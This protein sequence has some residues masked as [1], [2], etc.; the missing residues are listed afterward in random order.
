MKPPAETLHLGDCEKGMRKVKKESVD[1]IFTD[2]PYIAEMWE[3]AYKILAKGA[4]RVLKP[5]GFC[6]TYCPQYRLASVMD[7][8]RDA[9]L[10]YFWIIPQLCLSDKTSMVHQRKAICLHK[11]ILVFSKP[12][13]TK[14]PRA[15][16]DVVRGKRQKS[17]HPWQQSIHDALGIISRFADP[18]Q[19]LADPFTGSG[20]SLLAAQCLGLRI[21]G[22]EIQEETYHKAVYRLQQQP[23]TLSSFPA[24]LVGEEV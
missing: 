18:G 13:M 23:L 12:P 9:G 20:T 24:A 14:P 16:A 21:I 7:I 10:E 5:G 6:I 19:L 15:F 8:M 11:P 1:L 22:W 17:F 2:P 3:E 4:F